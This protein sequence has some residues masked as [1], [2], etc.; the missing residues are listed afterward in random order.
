MPTIMQKNNISARW[1]KDNISMVD[2]LDRLGYPPPKPV[3]KERVYLSMLRYSD[4]TPSFSVNDKT[5]T[6]YDHG[7][8][9][10]GNIID[11]GLLYWKGSSF[12]EVLQ[13]IIEVSNQISPEVKPAQTYQRSIKK[14]NEKP[15]YQILEIR[16]LGHNRVISDYLDSRGVSEVAQGR[17]KEVYYYVNDEAKNRKQ[18]FAAGWQNENGSWEIRSTLDYRGCL[19]H[20]AISFIADSPDRLAV[21]EGFFDYLSWLSENPL[22]KE[23]VLVLN[24]VS[25]LQAGIDKAKH[26]KDIALFFDNDATGRKANTAFLSALP[27]ATDYAM[28]YEGYKDYNEKI[29]SK[30]PGFQFNR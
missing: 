2:L 14:I 17:L 12:Q 15:N 24:S 29:V 5:G 8:G 3:G 7:E 9:R 28:L 16:E 25:L 11:F 26:F 30:P 18:F 13:K 19:G 23:S 10:G 20:K 1:V 21:F 6:W 4:T 22:A 27:N